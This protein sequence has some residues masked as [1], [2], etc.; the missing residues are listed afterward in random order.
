MEQTSWLALLLSCTLGAIL[1]TA[2]GAA[3]SFWSERLRVK[4]EVLLHVVGWSDDAYVRVIDLHM[5]K[6]AAYRGDK[7]YLQREEYDANSRALRSILIRASL[8]A[9]V[10]IVYGEGQELHLLRNLRGKL[11]SATQTLW[12]ATSETWDEIDLKTHEFLQ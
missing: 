5:S 8:D 7:P 4:S 9:E 10:A 12:G 2:L 3:V 1:A 11:L 6:H